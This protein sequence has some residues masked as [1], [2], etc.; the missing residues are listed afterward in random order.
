MHACNLCTMRDLGTSY[1]SAVGSVT[2]SHSISH[3]SHR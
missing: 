2:N 3:L 1:P